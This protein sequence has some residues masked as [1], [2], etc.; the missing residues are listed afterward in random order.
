MAKKY[1]GTIPDGGTLTNYKYANFGPIDGAYGL[2]DGVQMGDVV[3]TFTSGVN[4]TAKDGQLYF[5]ATNNMSLESFSGNNIVRHNLVKN[6]QEGAFSTKVQ[7][8]KWVAPI[9]DQ[10]KV[11]K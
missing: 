6:P 8:F 11:G 3:G 5:Q 10:Y 4:I 7:I 2:L 1:N 9:P